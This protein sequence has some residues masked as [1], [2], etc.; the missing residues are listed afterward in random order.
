LPDPRN[1]VPKLVA[2]LPDS[3]CLGFVDPYGD[4]TFNQAQLPVLITEI[5]E[6][7]AIA[8]DPDVKTHGSAVLKLARKA[9]SEVHT[10]LKFW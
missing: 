4:T 3:R 1:L 5:E 7:L 6:A 10:Y 8:E 9:S 2:L